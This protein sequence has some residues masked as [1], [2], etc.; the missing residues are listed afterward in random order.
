MDDLLKGKEKS[1][2]ALTMMICEEV[3]VRD[4]GRMGKL[5]R[6]SG[7]FIKRGG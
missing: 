3:R 2:P 1:S 5:R 7:R 6:G 4:G